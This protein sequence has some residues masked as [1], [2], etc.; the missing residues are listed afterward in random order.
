M[1]I[2]G[3]VLRLLRCCNNQ[4]FQARINSQW[5]PASAQPDISQFQ[6]DVLVGKR[7]GNAVTYAGNFHSIVA[8]P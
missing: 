4:R 7:V 8:R 5:E 3:I 6:H 2:Q 1:Q